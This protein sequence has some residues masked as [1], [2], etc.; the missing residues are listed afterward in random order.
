MQPSIRTLIAFAAFTAFAGLAA[1]SRSSD[2]QQAAT[3]ATQPAANIADLT[4]PAGQKQ[5]AEKALPVGDASRA[6]TEFRTVDSGNEVMFLYYGLSNLPA[7]YDKIAQS[8]SR[9]YQ[10]TSDSFRKQDLLKALKPR[11]DAAIAAAKD[12][13]YVVLSAQGAS[14]EAYDFSRKGFQ[15]TN[16]AQSGSYQYFFDNSN[17]TI[18]YTNGADHTFIKVDDEASARAIEE[19]RSHYRPLTVRLYTFAQ[20]ADPASNRVKLQILHTQLLDATGRVLAQS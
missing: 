1:C 11:I 19:M 4:S 7:D 3:P 13:R 20:D 2:T 12:S 6:L 17:Y 16:V 18:E 5:I 15:V 9:D 10:T 8:Y 14:L